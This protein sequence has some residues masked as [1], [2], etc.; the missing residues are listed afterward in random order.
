MA[1][2]TSM[3]G[4][5]TVA[6]VDKP[7]HAPNNTFEMRGIQRP[8]EFDISPNDYADDDRAEVVRLVCVDSDC[9]FVVSL[10]SLFDAL[11]DRCD[12]HANENSLPRWPSTK[13]HLTSMF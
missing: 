11:L 12:A 10:Y 3:L 4:G 9:N 13:L 8:I 5:A 7:G 2:R 1:R 6:G